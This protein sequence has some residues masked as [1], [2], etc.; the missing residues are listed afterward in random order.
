QLGLSIDEAHDA[1]KIDRWF[2]HHIQA[3]AIAE[4]ELAARAFG[5][6]TA[7]IAPDAFDAA[8]PPIT[9]LTAVSADLRTYKR[10]GFSDRRIAALIGATEHQVRQ[11]RHAIG[12]HPVYKRIDTCSAELEAHTQYFYSTYED[13]CEAK[14]TARRKVIILGGG[15]NRIGQGIEFDYCCVHAAIALQTEGIE[16]IMVNCNPETVS[17]D[18]DTSD[19]LYFEPVTLEDVLEICAIEKPY[20]VIIQLGGQTP[21]KLAAGLAAAG[22]R[23]LGTQPDAID[24]AEDRQRFGAALTKLGLQAP[25]WG[26]ASSLGEA[27]EVAQ[28]IGFPVMVRPSYVLGGRAMERIDSLAALDGYFRSISVATKG[29][30]GADDREAAVVGLPILIDKFLVDAIELDVDVVADH[31]GAV[32]IGGVMEHIESAGI[33]SGDS[34]CAL[35]PYSLPA[36]MISRIEHQA[37]A[38]AKELSVVGLMNAQFAIF[39]DD[40]FVLE[41]NP[42]ASRTIPFVSKAMG[43]SLAQVATR[44]MLGT[45]LSEQRITA[46]SPDRISVKEVVLPFI[47]FDGVDPRLGPEMR[48]TGEVMGIGDDFAEAFAKSQ[49]AASNPLPS[50]GNV[51]LAVAE[52]EVAVAL[53]QR[54]SA[55]GMNL[56]APPDL[57][58]KLCERGVCATAIGADALA[59]VSL[60]III[61]H[62]ANHR[63]A[64]ALRRSTLVQ[65]ISHVTTLR[66]ALAAAAAIAAIQRGAMSVSPL[67]RRPRAGDV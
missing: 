47:K 44:A 4:L 34:A 1:T 36:A 63:E 38:I 33:H 52:L 41:V 56:L 30:R 22:I 64:H 48:S 51:L 54:F 57:A 43:I 10:L 29:T 6:S 42:R 50:A 39:R 7:G 8:P 12:L 59:D 49:V 5:T 67:Q 25:P 15:P 46:R 2:L 60:A 40:V 18:Y 9:G 27:R 66:G 55:L 3:I 24:R 61:D 20:G 26:I 13:E 21:L 32:M 53:A 45:S 11:A 14:P 17:T 16:S 58:S 31:T 28:T 35:P 19:R 65:R 62:D 23:I 37:I